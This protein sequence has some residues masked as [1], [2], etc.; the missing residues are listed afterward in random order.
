MSR[1]RILFAANARKNPLPHVSAEMKHKIA[2]TIVCFVCSPPNIFVGKFMQTFQQTRS[3]IFDEMFTAVVDEGFTNIVMHSCSFFSFIKDTKIEEYQTNL[4]IAF[5]KINKR[6]T[7]LD[8]KY[9]DPNP[10]KQFQRWYDE[11]MTAHVS[12]YDA[13]ALA[14]STKSGL[15]SVRMVLL[16]QVDERGFV[17]YTNYNSRK[18][19]ELRENPNASLLFYWKELGRQIRIEGTVTTVS[20]EESDAYFQ[21]RPRESQISAI[22]SPQSESIASREE[23]ER[24]AIE[25]GLQYQNKPIPRPPHWGGYVLKPHRIEFW[26][27][28]EARLHDRILY[29][30]QKDESWKVMR[31]AP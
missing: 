8:E 19:N 5:N 21:S 25:V 4:Y 29:T 18:G 22:V 10:L 12:M 6:M 2:N 20:S 9:I 15:P 13:M 24:K 1:A 31:L 27:N 23:L 28:R 26:Q 14:T 11:A 7:L 17:F 16:K 3:K 30:L